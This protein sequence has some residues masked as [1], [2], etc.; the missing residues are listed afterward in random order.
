[1]GYRFG[2]STST[3]RS[4]FIESVDVTPALSFG[5]TLEY[6][7]RP[8][9]TLEFLW[10]HQDSELKVDYRQ[11]PPEGYNDRLTHLNVDTFQIGGLWMFGTSDARFRPYLDLLLDQWNS[12]VFWLENLFS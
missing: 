5:L 9:A 1:M 4:D 11:T 2:G 8:N 12:F 3:T 10:S 6:A 7:I